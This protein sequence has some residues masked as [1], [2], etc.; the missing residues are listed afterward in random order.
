[1]SLN[2]TQNT[3]F[4]F[5]PDETGK[6]RSL[7]LEYQRIS[8]EALRVQRAIEIA[9]KELALVISEAEKVKAEETSLFEEMSV[10]YDRDMKTLQNIAA[11]Q[12]LN[13]EI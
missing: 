11:N 3:E 13:G 6:I 5:T 9:E 12:I 1:M 4:A 7:T 8:K 2:E 10:K